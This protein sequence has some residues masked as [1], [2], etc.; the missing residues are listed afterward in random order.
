MARLVLVCGSMGAGKT[1]YSM[2]LAKEI[3]GVRFSIDPWMQRMYAKD[4]ASLDYE[5]IM[6]RVHRC[7][8]QIWEV[9]SQILQL[10]GNVI[11]DFGFSTKD[12]RESFRSKAKELGVDSEIHFLD[13]LESVRKQRVKQRNKNQ[14]PELYAFEVTEDMFDFME[15]KFEAP[16][17]QE[18]L[19]GHIINI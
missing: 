5:W 4:M 16:D 3:G 8:E 7:Y 19:N 1:T 17:S 6:E 2:S 12:Q 15:P 9:S 10:N 14:E 13:V 11:L 18:L